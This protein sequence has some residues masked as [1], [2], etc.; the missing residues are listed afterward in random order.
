MTSPCIQVCKIENKRCIGCNRT[1]EQI[2]AWSTMTDQQ[3]REAMNDS[4]THKTAI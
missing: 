3:R 4:A 2:A 1:L